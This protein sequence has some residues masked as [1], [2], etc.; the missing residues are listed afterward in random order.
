M[1]PSHVIELSLRDR[2][3]DYVGVFAIGLAVSAAVGLVIFVIW[4]PAFGDAIGYPIII[5]GA[6]LLAVGGVTGG[7]YR[8]MGIDPSDRHR[9]APRP[10]ANPTAIWQVIAGFAYVGIGSGV[11]ALF[12]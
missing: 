9:M 6:V 10:E 11:T 7:G 1:E 5:V 12:G 2:L 3:L 4:G 8:A